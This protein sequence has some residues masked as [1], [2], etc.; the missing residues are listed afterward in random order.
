MVS[1]PAILPGRHPGVPAIARSAG[2]LTPQIADLFNAIAA[3]GREVSAP[4]VTLGSCPAKFDEHGTSAREFFG[5][6]PV[7]PS[8]AR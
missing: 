7:Q 4:V 2:H 5:A 6:T 1:Y 3:S 8:L